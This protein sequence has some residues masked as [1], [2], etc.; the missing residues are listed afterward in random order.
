[1]LIATGA[2]LSTITKEAAEK[3][4][5]EIKSAPPLRIVFGFEPHTATTISTSVATFVGTITGVRVCPVD[6]RVVEEHNPQ[7]VVLG[8]DWLD[9][10]EVGMN[11]NPPRIIDPQTMARLFGRVEQGMY[12]KKKDDIWKCVKVSRVLIYIHAWL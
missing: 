1:M 3:L 8:A 4:G 6:V 11:F 12:Q 10:T 9:I 7:P 5:L 2:S